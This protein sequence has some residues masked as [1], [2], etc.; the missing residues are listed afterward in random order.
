MKRILLLMILFVGACYS[1]D[2]QW[3]FGGGLGFG[4]GSEGQFSV[5][6]A[7]EAGYYLT[8]SLTVGG[9]LSY[10]SGYNQFGIDP[11]ARWNFLKPTSPVR[12]LATVHAP[13]KFASDYFSYGFY[14]QPGISIA[15]GAK[16]RLECHV[17]AFGWGSVKSGNISVSSW[18]ATISS[19]NVTLG[20]VFAI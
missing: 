19:D 6:I 2:A 8:N 7:P 4:K 12:I 14:L 15:L 18:D 1:A 16:A 10:Y 13:L 20:V 17:G 9:K 3:Y 11:Y 5:Y